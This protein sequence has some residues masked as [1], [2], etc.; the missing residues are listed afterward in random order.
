MTDDAG[1]VGANSIQIESWVRLDPTL[2]YQTATF[3][4]G[5]LDKLE[6]AVGG[7]Q[8]V[9][10]DSLTY[11]F[12]VPTAQLKALF[13]SP[14]PSSRPGLAA[15]VGGSAPWGTAPLQAKAWS[16]YGY[17][18][19]SFLFGPEAVFELHGN[20]G[21][22]RALTPHR[23]AAWTWAAAF[24]ATIPCDAC[25]VFVELSSGAADTPEQDGL[26]H[27]GFKYAFSDNAHIDA[28]VG[29]GV[30]G[31]ERQEPFATLGFM[32]AFDL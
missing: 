30:W 31:R 17:V 8:G 18:A 29:S 1:V 20:L 25:F 15:A 14:E 4:Y 26:V 12:S 21:Y 5:L 3:T 28:T 32:V 9:E 22:A 10:R 13:I 19:T 6:F 24:A 27:G 7:A 2:L 11:T 16:S 23:F